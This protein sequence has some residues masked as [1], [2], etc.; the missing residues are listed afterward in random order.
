M[1]VFLVCSAAFEA[2]AEDNKQTS[3]DSLVGKYNGRMIIL[4]AKQREFDYQ[5]EIASADK[6][7]N[8]F[9]LESYCRDCDTPV[10]KRNNCSIT[11][12]NDGIK[13]TCKGKTFEEEYTF[14]EDKLRGT[15]HTNKYLYS[16]SVTKVVK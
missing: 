2:R 12:A 4:R 1:T 9:S 16:I 10:W 15:G 5:I 3:L 13:F 7:N 14:K 6:T 11:D 8:T